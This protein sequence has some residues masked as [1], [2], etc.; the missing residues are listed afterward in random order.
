MYEAHK[1]SW[2]MTVTGYTNNFVCLICEQ[3]FKNKKE[4]RIIVAGANQK[5]YATI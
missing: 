2:D 5:G 1:D 3:G 4:A